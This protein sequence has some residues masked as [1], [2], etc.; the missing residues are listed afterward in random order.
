MPRRF[1]KNDKKEQK[2]FRTFVP[3]KCIQCSP[4]S[5]DYKDLAKLQKFLTPHGMLFSRKRSGYCNQCQK[6]FKLA[7]KR[8]RFI[9]LL[10]YVS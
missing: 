3:K 8:A 5:F 4:K 9:A 2:K 7:V 1:E 10:P 6:A